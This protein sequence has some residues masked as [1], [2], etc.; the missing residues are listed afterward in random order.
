[1]LVFPH[2]FTCSRLDYGQ[3]RREGQG[4]AEPASGSV[5]RN[6]PNTGSAQ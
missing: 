4:V 2:F 6:P 3:N 1:L 5:R